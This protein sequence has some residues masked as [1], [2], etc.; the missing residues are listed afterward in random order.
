M[1]ILHFHFGKDGG[2]EQFFVNL[3]R[4]MGRRGVE[5]RLVIRPRRRWRPDVAKAAELFAESHFRS[6]SLDR[7]WLPMRVR[8]M[9][10]RWKPDAIMAWMSRAGHLLPA[11]ADCLR[12]VRLGDYPDRLTQFDNA[13]MLICNTP[14]IL[15]RVRNLGWTR[16]ACV[17]T[18]FTRT[19][20]VA[21]AARKTLD[22]P[23]SAPLISSVG[24]LVNRKGFD[25]LI[26]AMPLVPEAY[27]WIVGD[28]PEKDNLK[29]LAAKLG[30]TGRVRFAGWR[31]D[32]RPF[33]AASDI[34]AMASS[35]EPLGNVVLEGWAQRKPVVA[36]RSEGPSWFVKDASNGL[37]V[38]IGD[39]E[40][41]AAAFHRLLDNDRLA[42][43]LVAGGEAALR[44]RFSEDAVVDRYLETFGE[45]SSRRAA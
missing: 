4:A 39:H 3:V 12:C 2:A 25:V 11:E 41:F 17:I 10:R 35:H 9:I 14:G 23:P 29:T 28:G 44:G 36:T 1:K 22:T 45:R 5:Q 16:R 15:E 21:A 40:G 24:R 13:D 20:Q 34:S 26:R 8:R 37:L 7:F 33:I 38:D 31:H 18:N 43:K 19:E 6:T 42:H 32:P 27:L 30:V